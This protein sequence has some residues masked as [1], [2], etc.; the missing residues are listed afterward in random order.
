MD[1]KAHAARIHRTRIGMTP[2]TRLED[3]FAISS[4]VRKLHAIVDA[5]RAGFPAVGIAL[6]PN[7]DR[8]GSVRR[9]Q[10]GNTGKGDDYLA[11]GWET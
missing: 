3:M 10:S 8:Q 5:T 6:R 11:A 4:P 9:C 1:V 7:I 2:G